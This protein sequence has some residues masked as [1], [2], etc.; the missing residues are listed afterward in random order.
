MTK[1]KAEAEDGQS[2]HKKRVLGVRCS[3][4]A[5][6]WQVRGKVVSEVREFNGPSVDRLCDP[7][8]VYILIRHFITY[9]MDYI[10][11]LMHRE[12]DEVKLS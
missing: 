1:E 11:D 6:N 3:R 4:S 10:G 5:K 9:V 8:F 2:I 12:L 7:L